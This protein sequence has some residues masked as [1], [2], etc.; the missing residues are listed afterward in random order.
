[1][2]YITDIE[3]DPAFGKRTC[4]AADVPTPPVMLQPAS[5][6]SLPSKSLPILELNFAELSILILRR[7][8]AS[9]ED[10]SP[11]LFTRKSPHVT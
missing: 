7:A 11:V 5:R 9:L 4:N 6:R 2:W 3:I 1:M 8:V 10:L